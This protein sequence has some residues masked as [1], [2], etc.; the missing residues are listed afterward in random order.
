MTGGLE[1]F[2]KLVLITFLVING[3]IGAMESNLAS[4]AA[5]GGLSVSTDS[6]LVG[7][8]AQLAGDMAQTPDTPVQIGECTMAIS[9][10]FIKKFQVL[11]GHLEPDFSFKKDCIVLSPEINL[12]TFQ[13]LY[14][15]MI[16]SAS[17]ERYSPR[18]LVDI[19]YLAHSLI[20]SNWSDLDVVL[21]QL[22]KVAS[23]ELALEVARNFPEINVPL[24][25]RAYPN[26]SYWETVIGEVSTAFDALSWSPDGKYCFVESH[27]TNGGGKRV[28]GYDLNEKKVFMSTQSKALEESYWSPDSSKIFVISKLGGKLYNISTKE[29]VGALIRDIKL[30]YWSP[31]STQYA[32]CLERSNLAQ[33]YNDNAI[34][35]GDPILFS[36]IDPTWISTNSTVEYSKQSTH[37][38][39]NRL[40]FIQTGATIQIYD[41]QT[42][43]AIG[44]PISH[45]EEAKWI[46]TEP[47][48]LF[49]RIRSASSY[50]YLSFDPRTGI[51]EYCPIGDT[52]LS[53]NGDSCYIRHLTGHGGSAEL[54]NKK[55]VYFD[56]A[57]LH[58]IILIQYILNVG[59]VYL[60]SE[61]LGLLSAH[62][63]DVLFKSGWL[64]KQNTSPYISATTPW[65]PS[66]DY[67]QFFTLPAIEQTAAVGP[68]PTANNY[69]NWKKVGL[70]AVAVAGVVAAA[71]WCKSKFSISNKK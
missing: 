50:N 28:L 49:M 39:N 12:E 59:P 3:L 5:V 36:Q 1:M 43:K 38:P 63:Q 55:Y 21:N 13:A 41:N 26:V 14:E 25:I 32:V 18:Q 7:N 51:Y 2:K 42:G 4:L 53:L 35:M 17:V 54:F 44:Y 20:I 24:N 27:H 69:I 19:I 52:V 46:S 47:E 45:V 58:Q 23:P 30:V 67:S 60:R 11:A 70:A 40:F 57:S 31:D 56:E 6:H 71:W 37:S 16:G 62:Q 61:S 34:P 29:A 10:E 33:I 68:V 22:K 9:Q 64:L 48:K 66:D 65:K 8:T 15:C